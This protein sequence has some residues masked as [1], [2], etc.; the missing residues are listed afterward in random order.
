MQSRKP[1]AI[2]QDLQ[3]PH[4]LKVSEN[5]PESFD[6]QHPAVM[7]PNVTP[8]LDIRVFRIKNYFQGMVG[9]PPLRLRSKSPPGQS[10]TTDICDS[11]NPS[12]APL[13]PP[14]SR[15]SSIFPE[16]RPMESELSPEVLP[17]DLPNSSSPTLLPVEAEATAS[18]SPGASSASP[19]SH[20]PSIQYDEAAAEIIQFD[21]PLEEAAC[22]PPASNVSSPP[23]NEAN[24]E[25]PSDAP[26][27]EV[28]RPSLQIYSERSSSLE[29]LN[30]ASESPVPQPSHNPSHATSYTPPRPISAPELATTVTPEPSTPVSSPSASFP[31]MSTSQASLRQ[32]S[33]VAEPMNTISLDYAGDKPGNSV[34]INQIAKEKETEWRESRLSLSFFDVNTAKRRLASK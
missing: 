21:V 28:S 5:Q 30:D 11:T 7:A 4:E 1:Q 2:Y 6:T 29:A 8:F 13:T 33:A 24:S 25:A 23:S 20:I 31:V 26:D 10:Q 19:K 12:G 27:A 22:P 32:P 14:P 3:P 15:S 17:P 16:N 9:G 34:D 18:F